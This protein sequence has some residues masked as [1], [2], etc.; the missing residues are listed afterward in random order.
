MQFKKDYTNLE[1]D[2]NGPPLFRIGSKL[3]TSMAEFKDKVET[4]L[5]PRNQND[6]EAWPTTE[7]STQ[8]LSSNTVMTLSNP[9]IISV[10]L[11]NT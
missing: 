10:L 9:G 8:V 2:S 7:T 11:D 6:D 3:G 4:L 5:P 1:L